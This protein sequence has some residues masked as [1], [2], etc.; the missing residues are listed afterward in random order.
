[1]RTLV[2][3]LRA[4]LMLVVVSLGSAEGTAAQ[5]A[6]SR[7][8][9]GVLASFL[10]L[11]DATT[12]NAGV[13][14]RLSFDVAQWV[15]I[16][17]EAGFFANDEVHPASTPTLRWTLTRRRADAFFGV[18]A[19]LRREKFGAFAK[20][21]PGVTHLTDRGGRCAGDSCALF[22]PPRPEY[23]TEFALDVGGVFEV[24]PTVRTVTRLDVGDTII[25]HRSFAPP[26]WPSECS[27]H[28][29]S[30]RVGGGFRF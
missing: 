23:R 20:L 25:R 18:K 13:G 4:P 15:A 17:G 29:L 27:S 9:V 28:N 6:E 16:E 21:R 5:T 11:S 24:Y 8:E 30:W 19:G 3:R 22:L 7:V 26:C 12:T 2:G 14:G 1:M 10:R